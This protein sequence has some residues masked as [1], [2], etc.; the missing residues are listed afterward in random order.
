MKNANVTAAAV[1][2]YTRRKYGVRADVVQAE[3]DLEAAIE[4][5]MSN[6]L[7]SLETGLQTMIVDSQPLPGP[8]KT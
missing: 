2:W 5:F 7:S 3:L 8:S 1:N 6:G 4:G